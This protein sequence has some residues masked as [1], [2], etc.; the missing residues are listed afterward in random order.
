L[1][2]VYHAGVLARLFASCVL[3]ALP[4]P[5]AADLGLNLYGLAY[6]FDRDRA[7]DS[8]LDNE[9]IAGV[10]LR[11][12]AAR[13]ERLHW[14]ADL[15]VYRDSGRNTALLAGAGALWKVTPGWRV[16]GA[17]AAFKS[18]TYNRGRAFVAPLPLAAYEFRSV[19]LNVTFIPRL[20]KINDMATLAVW[21]TW[22]P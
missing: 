12:R 21:L 10:G 4:L 6:H 1:P 19:T 22:W 16:G 5:A 3:L 13:D 11:Y 14:I 20:S 15:S 9:F 18:D 2:V 17:F 7:R 8:G